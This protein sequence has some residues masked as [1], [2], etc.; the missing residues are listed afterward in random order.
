MEL[1]LNEVPSEGASVVESSE[2]SH[3]KQKRYSFSHNQYLKWMLPRLIAFIYLVILFLWIYEAEGGIGSQDNSLFGWHALLMSFFVIVLLQEAT[4]AYASP[5][6]GPVTTNYGTLKYVLE[7]FSNANHH[8]TVCRN[9]F[10]H[11]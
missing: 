5:L 4:L 3:M 1:K 6:I 9:N 2:L 10:S 8:Q 11:R 7:P